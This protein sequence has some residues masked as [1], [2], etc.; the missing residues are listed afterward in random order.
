MGEVEREMVIAS[1]SVIPEKN[2]A[3]YIPPKNG[4]L[5]IILIKVKT[6]KNII[7]NLNAMLRERGDLISTFSF[8]KNLFF[9]EKKYAKNKLKTLN[10]NSGKSK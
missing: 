6:I 10:E 8:F 4:N 1:T 5:S 9:L 7:P 3:I 2:E